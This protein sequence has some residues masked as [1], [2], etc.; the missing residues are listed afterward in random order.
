MSSL[1]SKCS[2]FVESQIFYRTDD[3]LL[4][5][6]ACLFNFSDFGLYL[7]TI[8][9]TSLFPIVSFVII[10]IIHSAKSKQVSNSKV[11]ILT[12]LI[13][14]IPSILTA[15]LSLISKTESNPASKLSS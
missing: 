10:L 2:I 12:L 15:F 4:V 3:S 6:V 5:R 8:I 13:K 9:L 7:S 1:I 14:A 11:L